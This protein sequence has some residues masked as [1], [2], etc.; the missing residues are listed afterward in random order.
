MFSAIE[1]AMTENTGGYN[2]A[3]GSSNETPPFI[4][5]KLKYLVNC[6]QLFVDH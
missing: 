4:Y 6:N 1:V 5:F 2:Y 3:G